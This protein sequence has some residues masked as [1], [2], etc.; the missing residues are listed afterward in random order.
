MTKGELRNLVI[1]FGGSVS[2]GNFFLASW[3]E[4]TY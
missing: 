1:F 4:F 2:K 3:D